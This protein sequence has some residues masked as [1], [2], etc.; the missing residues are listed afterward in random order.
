MGAVG[1][2]IKL[3]TSRERLREMPPAADEEALSLST[4]RCRF[5]F[6][7]VMMLGELPRG[8]LVDGAVLA[9]TRGGAQ[10]RDTV[11]AHPRWLGEF[12]GR[13]FT[14]LHR[15]SSG[16]AGSA[17]EVSFKSLL[18]PLGNSDIRSCVIQTTNK[19]VQII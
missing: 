3:A 6:I 11:T 15:R 2:G 8:K 17:G 13:P 9:G 4:D 12:D 14:P 18:F 16:N 1:D 7:V 5:T 19:H 10:R